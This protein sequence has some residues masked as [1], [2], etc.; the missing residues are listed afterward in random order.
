MSNVAIIPARGGSKR[1]PRKNILPLGGVPL[2]GRVIKACLEANVFDRIIVS[3]EDE[4]IAYIAKTYGASI[5]NRSES[6]AADTSKVVEVC[7]DVLK[8]ID[9][10]TFCCVYATAALI[11]PDTIKASYSVFLDSKESNC[12]MGVSKYNY[13]PVQALKVN[14][15]NTA[16]LLM[17]EYEKMQ[18]QFHPKIRVSN[19][20]FYWGR[21]QSFLEGKTFYCSSL[22][23]ID[24]PSSE[25]CDI[26]TKDDYDRLIGIFN[27]DSLSS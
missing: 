16:K 18:S 12:L 14:A 26:D 19:G 8:S 9:C 11:K 10:E 22:K 20:T 1:L 3:T 15:D 17:P 6:L 7:V 24:I 23:T 2:I 4:E 21:K 25:V 27:E 13:S 5:H